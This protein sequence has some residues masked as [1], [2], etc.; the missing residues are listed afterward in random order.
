[1]LNIQALT[2]RLASLPDQAL[3]QFAAMHKDDPYSLA[4]AVSESNRRQSMRS[5]QAQPVQEQPT[6]AEQA[7]AGM[8]PDMYESGIAAIAPEDVAEFAGGGIVSFAEGG[9]TSGQRMLRQAQD[10]ARE[11]QRQKLEDIKNSFPVRAFRAVRD[12]K[13]GPQ[14]TYLPEPGAPSI[15]A[16]PEERGAIQEEQDQAAQ[17]QEAE[18]DFPPTM[19]ELMSPYGRRGVAPGTTPIYN[20]GA[21]PGL[22]PAT[23]DKA[24]ATGGKGGARPSGTAGPMTMDQIR[25]M[26]LKA[27][28]DPEAIISRL[29]GGERNISAADIDVAK[30]RSTGYENM[31]AG[32]GQLGAERETRAKAGLEG[33][34]GQEEKNKG[35]AFLQAGLAIL[36]APSDRG[37]FAAIGQGAL[38]GLGAYKVDADKLEGRREKLQESLDQI[39]DLRRQESMAT[40]EKKLELQGEIKKAELRGAERTQQLYKDV[41]GIRKDMAGNLVEGFLKEKERAE[42]NQLRREQIAATR[43]RSSALPRSSV[44]DLAQMRMILSRDIT[45]LRK[46][47]QGVGLE[48]DEKIMLAQYESE[49]RQVLSALAE[50]SGVPLSQ[51]PAGGKVSTSST[52]PPGFELD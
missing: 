11:I 18:K 26:Y 36:S 52:L 27:G 35:M 4:L 49:L 45:E 39:S 8:A 25:D 31:L 12:F 38:A 30:T 6:V 5:A 7:V 9:R 13:A 51:K 29:E 44:Q 17:I 19:E 2:N 22:V 37:A 1:M 28:Y 46:K 23:E 24:I 33:L 42:T 3:Q 40:G 10:Y 41:G 21:R 16:S 47:D 20:Q 50:R 43:E 32:L 48:E 34:A 15:Y 14:L